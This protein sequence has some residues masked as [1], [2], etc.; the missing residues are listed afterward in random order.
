MRSLFRHVLLVVV[1]AAIGGCASLPPNPPRTPE[2]AG[3]D[4]A[5]TPLGRIAAASVGEPASPEISAFRLL[6]I[7]DQAFNARLALTR[8]ATKYVDAQYYLL[9]PDDVGLRF[10]TE[11]RDAA[12]RGVRV[13][14]LVDDLYAGGSDE[15]LGTLAAHDNVEV[16][17]F[18]PLPVRGFDM[19]PRLL[20]SLHEFGR[21]NRRM[22]NKLFIADNAFAITG[23]RNMA[24]EYFMR[25]SSANFIDLDLLSAGPVVHKLSSVFDDYWNS[26]YTYPAQVLG[27]VPVDRAEARRRFDALVRAAAPDSPSSPLD[28]FDR[29]PVEFELARGHVGL[30][31]APVQLFADSPEK[32]GGRTAVGPGADTVTERALAVFDAAQSEAVIVSPYL[33]PGKRG[34]AMLEHAAARHVS[35]KLFTNSLGSTDEPLVHW[36]YKRYR[37]A[38]LKLGVHI[39]EVGATL[40]RQSGRFGEFRRS[41]GRLHAKAALID[42]R[43]LYV[44][45][46]N[47]DLRSSRVNTELA[48]VIDSPRLGEEAMHL[49]ERDGYASMYRLRLREPDDRIEWVSV[50][51][52]G[53][54][55]ATV[56]EPEGSW[57]LRFKTWLLSPLAREDLL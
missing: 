38:M 24:A 51:P 21:I 1:L 9:S 34:L 4:T 29:P 50:G 11:L 56:D 19:V 39:Y 46:M 41:L 25:H 31:R 45:S 13:R 23:G 55:I 20:L 3:T 36:G 30:V 32:A 42:R 15:L 14:L 28:P 6:P 37:K 43:W 49:L 10:V 35:V 7:G 17:I 48:L 53:E 52:D 5:E 16:R 44:G 22:H 18:N 57:W 2:F 26:P 54:D 8:R 12:A 40:S 33:I 47:L 27:L